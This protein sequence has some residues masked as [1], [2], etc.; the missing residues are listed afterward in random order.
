MKQKNHC[1]RVRTMFE[2]AVKLYYSFTS[3]YFFQET[4]LVL[5]PLCLSQ[6]ISTIFLGFGNLKILNL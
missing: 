5:I 2:I 3:V 1:Q 4:W 6:E